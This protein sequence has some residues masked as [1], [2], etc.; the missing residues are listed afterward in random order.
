MAK[1]F[2]ETGCALET[3]RA[4]LVGLEDS[5]LKCNCG[6][7]SHGKGRVVDVVF[8]SKG[9]ESD[10]W[11]YMGFAVLVRSYESAKYYDYAYTLSEFLGKAQIANILGISQEFMNGK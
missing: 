9:G 4:L 2:D 6:C 5:G 11:Y 3:L 7:I 8:E 1:T 10:F